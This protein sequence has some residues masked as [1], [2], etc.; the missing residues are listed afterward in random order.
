MSRIPTLRRDKAKV[1]IM[2][3]IR[4]LN[5]PCQIWRAINNLIKTYHHTLYF[6]QFPLLNDILI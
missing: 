3:D 5:P 4:I 2:V 6:L 1:Q